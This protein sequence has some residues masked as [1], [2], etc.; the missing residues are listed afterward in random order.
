LYLASSARVRSV[1]LV[2]LL[3]RVTNAFVI[4]WSKQPGAFLLPNTMRPAPYA[5]GLN[6]IALRRGKRIAAVALA[7][8]L[9]GILYA[10]WR[11][12]RPFDARRIRAPRTRALAA[13]S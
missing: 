9:A 2:R 6:T 8:R 4:C 1:V 3:K 5:S 11:D 12:N 7:C 13:A 10:M